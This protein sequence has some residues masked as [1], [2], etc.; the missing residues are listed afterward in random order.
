MRVSVVDNASKDRRLLPVLKKVVD[1]ARELRIATACISF[2]G[3]SL[4]ERSVESLLES[5]GRVEFLVGLDLSGTD[6]AALW[7]LHEWR[8]QYGD[9]ASWYCYRDLAPRV[10]Y[11][12]KL[13][14]ALSPGAFTA[15]VGS[16]NLTEGGLRRNIEVNLVLEACPDEEVVSDLWASYNELKFKEPRIRPDEE[17]IQLF[18]R[19]HREGGRARE[20]KEVCDLREALREKA[21]AL[22]HPVAGLNDL[23]G[24]QRLVYKQLPIGDF[25][26]SDVYRWADAF[27]QQYP[28]NQ[29]VRA[30]IRQVL[31]QLRDMG[32]LE[33]KGRGLWSRPAR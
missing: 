28:D 20:K 29:N 22:A 1:S 2:S 3:L 8:C 5:S 21:A 12:P 11:H 14:V 30:K 19:L 33:H 24:W 15:I 32:L 23:H 17:F 16:S 27:R 26:T 25:R 31:Q 18:E 6:P 7:R 13:Y 9:I 10:I 4:V